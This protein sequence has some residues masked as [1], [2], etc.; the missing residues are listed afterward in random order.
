MITFTGV[1]TETFI[2][3]KYTIINLWESAFVLAS[4]LIACLLKYYKIFNYNLLSL[5]QQFFY[6]FLVLSSS[7]KIIIFSDVDIVYFYGN[8]LKMFII[9][10]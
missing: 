4:P 9:K 10:T 3:I 8:S 2:K 7:V 1:F 6:I 5:Y